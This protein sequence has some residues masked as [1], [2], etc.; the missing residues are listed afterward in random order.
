MSLPALTSRRVQVEFVP[1]V[2]GFYVDTQL[3]IGGD[4]SR[5]YLTQQSLDDLGDNN[6]NKN[7]PLCNGHQELSAQLARTIALLEI[8]PRFI[9][10]TNEPYAAA[11]FA[12]RHSS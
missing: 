6:H 2:H 10:G 8:K 4:I 7:S 12:L 1:S 11:R 9:F 5:C 3:T